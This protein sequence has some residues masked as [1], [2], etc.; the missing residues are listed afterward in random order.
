V[1]LPRIR[2]YK[3]KLSGSQVV[4]DRRMARIA[5][6]INDFFF[7]TRFAKA[8]RMLVVTAP[9]VHQLFGVEEGRIGHMVCQGHM[10]R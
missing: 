4:Q 2:F 5:K 8:S 1:K 3:D 9:S 7:A 6:L 10:H